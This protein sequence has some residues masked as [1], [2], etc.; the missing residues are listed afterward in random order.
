MAKPTHQLL[1]ESLS[2][3][4]KSAIRGI[5]QTESLQRHDQERLEKEGWL[6][7]I[8][9]GWYILKQPLA[10]KGDSTVWYSSFWDFASIYLPSRFKDNYCLSANASIDLHIG[11]TTIPKQL[12]VM[13]QKG[14][15]SVID[16][17]FNTSIV[18]YQELKTFPKTIE[19][20]RGINVMPLASALHRVAPAFFQQSPDDAEI[21]LRLVDLTSLSRELLSGSN[22]SSANRIIGAYRFI[23]ETQRA[24]RLEED[25]LAAGYQVEP[26]NP[27]N[28]KTPF[29]TASP[30]AHSPY[31][32]RI[33]I[34]WQQMRNDV[35]SIFP[36]EPGL[37]R[38]SEKYFAQLEKIYVNDAYN[39]LSIEGYEVSEEL[40]KKIAAGKWHPDKSMTDQQQ[41]NAMAAKGYRQTFEKVKLSI[42]RILHKKNSGQIIKEDLHSWYS[43]LFSPSVKAGILNPT[44]LAGFRTHQVYIRNSMHTPLPTHALIDA[45]DTLFECLINEPHAAVRA[46][47]GHFIFVFIHPYMD[48]NGRIGRFLMNS[49]FAS[50]GFPWTIVSVAHREQYLKALEKASVEQDIR[51]FAKFILSEMSLNF[52]K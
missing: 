14:G 9:R 12:L 44:Q 45:M 31:A 36:D 20:I 41:M 27:F 8:I 30:R 32:A 3:A 13:A 38:A 24:K 51:L 37:P 5:I 15:S 50:G 33:A 25:L 52:R 49:L 22:I 42:N 43:A 18:I 39:S 17:P 34:M 47:L 10:K 2:R 21:A 11:L 28:I 23:G 48:G 46:V 4:K 35:L 19:Q 6:A 40:I 7:R 16:L 29:L 26:I 1:A